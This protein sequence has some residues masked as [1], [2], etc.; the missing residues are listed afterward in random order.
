MRQLRPSSISGFPVC[1]PVQQ[2]PDKVGA[3]TKIGLPE[4]FQHGRQV[5]KPT[6]RGLFENS[7]RARHS[8]MVPFGLAAPFRLV[9]QN[10]SNTSLQSEQNGVALTRIEPHKTL[11]GDSVHNTNFK[12]GRRGRNPEAHR[13]RRTRPVQLGQYSFRDQNVLIEDGEQTDL[14]DQHKVVQRRSVG[15]NDHAGRSASGRLL[16]SSS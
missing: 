4:A 16:S 11:V 8:Y 3:Q 2:L 5:N 15:D 1:V 14:V 10:Q 12:P 13:F 7:Q 9:D 6:L